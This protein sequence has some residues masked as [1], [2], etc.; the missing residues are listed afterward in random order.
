MIVLL[1][2]LLIVQKFYPIQYVDSI[3]KSVNKIRSFE[4][5]QPREIYVIKH[6]I[7]PFSELNNFCLAL[8]EY[9]LN[10]DIIYSGKYV[11]LI[12]I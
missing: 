12:Q 9:K 7:K 2:R 5:A 11:L 10:N 8:T 1:E 4:T 3:K 6:A